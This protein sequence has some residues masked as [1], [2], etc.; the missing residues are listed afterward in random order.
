MRFE[1]LDETLIFA[2]DV[3]RAASEPILQ[4]YRNCAIR[5]KS[6]STEVTRANREAETVMR[7]MIMVRYP[8]HATLGEEFDGA[9]DLQGS[10]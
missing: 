8:E 2:L 6:D 4:H 5:L 3:A 7:E 1:D 10:R 9:K